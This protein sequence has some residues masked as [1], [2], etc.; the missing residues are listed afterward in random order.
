LLPTPGLT[1]R[2]NGPS[3]VSFTVDG[4]K[5]NLRNVGLVLTYQARVQ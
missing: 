1:L 4:P 3:P 5:D 2:G